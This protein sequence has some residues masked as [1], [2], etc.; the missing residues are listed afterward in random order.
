MQRKTASGERFSTRRMTAIHRQ[1][2]LGTKVLVDNGV[3]RA[4]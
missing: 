4:K 2:P 1:L 3:R